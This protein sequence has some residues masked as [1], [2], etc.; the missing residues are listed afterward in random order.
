MDRLPEA[1]A[2]HRRLGY[3]ED[4]GEQSEEG[5]QRTAD[6]AYDLSPYSGYERCSQNAFDQGE[7]GSEYAGS[8]LQEA[9]MEEVEVLVHHQSGANRIHQLEYA[10]HQQDQP[11]DYHAYPLEPVHNLLSTSALIF[12][13]IASGG[14]ISPFS[15]EQST[16]CRPLSTSA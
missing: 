6:D 16:T 3:V 15:S 12:A 4:D 11:K 14:S 1:A 13:K 7:G 8:P 10:R 2:V 9:Q 5:Q